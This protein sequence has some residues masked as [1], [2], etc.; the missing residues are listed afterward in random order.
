MKLK[1]N[2]NI[3]SFLEAV[4]KCDYEVLFVTGEGDQLNLKST[5]S[6]FVFTAVIAGTL[7]K[8]DGEI[9]FSTS[10]STYLADYLVE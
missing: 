4:Q 10:D 5:L 8:L 3:P 2:V 7:N 9:T 6:Q 1:N